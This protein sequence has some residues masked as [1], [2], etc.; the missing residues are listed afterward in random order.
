MALTKYGPKEP[1]SPSVGAPCPL[2]G[3]AFQ[4]G[5]FTALVRTTSTSKYGNSRIE[6]HWVCATRP[7]D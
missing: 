2:C 7:A 3:T 6:V 4:A 5:D 1:L